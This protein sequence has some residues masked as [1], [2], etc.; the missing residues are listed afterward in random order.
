[1]NKKIYIIMFSI[2]ICMTMIIT[3]NGTQIK[4]VITE[5]ELD[6]IKLNDNKYQI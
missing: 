3:L 5:V 1:M 6:K 2:I 4:K